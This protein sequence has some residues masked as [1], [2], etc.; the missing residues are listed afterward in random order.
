MRPCIYL[1]FDIQ[2]RGRRKGLG[3]VIHAHTHSHT[4]TYICICPEIYAYIRAGLVDVMNERLQ[5]PF[6]GWQRS[7]TIGHLKDDREPALTRPYIYTAMCS[8]V[9]YIDIY[10]QS[11]SQK[12][13]LFLQTFLSRRDL[14]RWATQQQHRAKGISLKAVGPCLSTC[15]VYAVQ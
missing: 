7:L 1:L 13:V 12:I 11:Q 9:Y 10:I 6:Y 2:V 5:L 3:C 4:H 14:L 15:D 8:H